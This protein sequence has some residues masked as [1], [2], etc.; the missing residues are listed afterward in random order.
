M[1]NRIFDPASQIVGRSATN[2]S[3]AWTGHGSGTTDYATDGLNRLPSQTTGGA[4][5]TFS[6]DPRS[7]RASDGSRTYVFDS[8]NKSRGTATAPW[9]YDP[10]GRLSG[11]ST[12]PGTPPAIAYESYVDNLV[13][14]RTPGS[15]SVQRRH[16][17]GPGV[18]EPLVWYEGSG[19]TDRRFLQADER[20][21]IVA[22]SNGSAAVQNVNT[23]DEYGRTQVSNNSW[24]ARFAYTGQRYFGGFGLYHYKSRMYD[25]KAGRFLQPDP[26][27][28]GGGMN[29]Y[30][31]VGG[32][33]VNF[34]DPLGLDQTIVVTAFGLLGG[35][36]GGAVFGPVGRTG[37][38]EAELQRQIEENLRANFAEHGTE[39]IVVN[40]GLLSTRTSSGFVRAAWW[41]GR[42]HPILVALEL[43]LQH[44]EAK[45]PVPY[46]KIKATPQIRATLNRIKMGKGYPHRNDGATFKN[47]EGKLPVRAGVTYREYV[48]PTPGVS[49]AGM[50]RLVIASDSSIYYTPDHYNT[51]FL[52][53]R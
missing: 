6:H 13:A 14:E 34:T 29:M 30:A 1:P 37:M 41:G 27:G 24:Q 18:D 12:S 9:H 21:S 53:Q 39:D 26:I 45:A 36:G 42:M 47:R 8:E 38:S 28:Y 50:Q 23:Y 43:L 49:H 33:P 44:G 46:P 10:L 16:V 11:V 5:T 15:S 19:T 7:N 40:G 31:Y 20:G 35:N 25:P 4:T 51:F 32:D 17:F 3:Y 2:N 22:V 48:V 52:V